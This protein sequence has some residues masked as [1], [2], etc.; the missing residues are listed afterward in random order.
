MPTTPP[1]TDRLRPE[2]VLVRLDAT[3][4]EAVIAALVR[5]VATSDAVADPAALEADVLAREAAMSTG[6]GHGIALP[7]ARSAS[8]TGT[9]LA[10]ATLAQP[11]DFASL[12]GAPVEIAVLLAGPEAERGEHVRLLSRVSLLLSHADVRRRLIEATTAEDALAVLRDAE[13]V[14]S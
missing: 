13:T 12:D 7:H 11:V 8:T 5:A 14:A 3:T 6:V 9:V 1:L 10:F 2:Q 4:K